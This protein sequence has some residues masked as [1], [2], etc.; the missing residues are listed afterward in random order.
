MAGK[1]AK[2]GTVLRG[3]KVALKAPTRVALERLEEQGRPVQVLG[4]IRNGKL[5]ID[6]ASLEETA[7]RFPNANW[8]FV[9]MNAPFDPSP[10]S[11]AS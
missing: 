10:Y 6:Q 7:R 4:R 3:A 9:A 2:T 11:A 8:A 5:E 1:R